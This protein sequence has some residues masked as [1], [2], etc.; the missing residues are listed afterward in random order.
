MGLE[1][2]QFH[3]RHSV[4]DCWKKECRGEV[5][6]NTVELSTVELSAVELTEKNTARKCDGAFGL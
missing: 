2:I 4:E 1:L 6:L 3:R 5:E